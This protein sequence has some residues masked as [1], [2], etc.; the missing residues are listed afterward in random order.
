[1]E[2][3]EESRMAR[4]VYVSEIQGGNIRGRPPVKWRDRVQEY[5]RVRGE[6]SL[7]SERNFEPAMLLNFG[8]IWWR[9]GGRRDARVPSE[10][11][12]VFELA[13]VWL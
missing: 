5:I 3:M 10:S 12:P 6:R 2:Q 11:Q 1:M 4:R 7:R 13:W 8:L 9:E